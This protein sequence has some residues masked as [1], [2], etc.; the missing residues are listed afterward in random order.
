MSLYRE[1]CP[2]CC[3]GKPRLQLQAAW[4][5]SC[6]NAPPSRSR[7]TRAAARTARAS[8]DEDRRSAPSR[9]RRTSCRGGGCS[10]GHRVE[11]IDDLIAGCL[12]HPDG[13]RPWAISAARGTWPA[14]RRST[15]STSPKPGADSSG[16][17]RTMSAMSGNPRR[18]RRALPG[19]NC[20]PRTARHR[21]CRGRSSA[22]RCG[23]PAASPAPLA[24]A[25]SPARPGEILY[26]RD[27]LD[28]ATRLLDES[29]ELAPRG[30]S[31]SSC[32]PLRGDGGHGAAGS[33]N[34]FAATRLGAQC[35]DANA[36]PVARCIDYERTVLGFTDTDPVH[37]RLDG[38]G[39]TAS[40]KGP[41]N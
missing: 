24:A 31:S 15:G 16:P 9:S 8:L 38:G 18:D 19:E 33:G 26:E 7:P 6:C 35:A 37:Y 25:H 11:G 29:G 17:P 5:T 39:T 34:G 13:M 41:R 23:W 1:S 32:S 27:E 4:R 36:L 14:M 12:A 40:R 2:R 22:P 20:G 28:T 10:L 21:R 3:R 30:G